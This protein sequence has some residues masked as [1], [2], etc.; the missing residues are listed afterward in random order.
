MTGDLLLPTVTKHDTHHFGES[1][2]PDKVVIPGCVV[3]RF[4][5]DTVHYTELSYWIDFSEGD[6]AV[7]H[8][9]W[10]QHAN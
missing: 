9:L 10:F 6:K 1:T 3:Y 4:A 7:F 8:T 2:R 5:D